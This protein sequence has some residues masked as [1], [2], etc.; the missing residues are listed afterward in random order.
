MKN[1]L[2]RLPCGKEM[3]YPAE[4]VKINRRGGLYVAVS[5]LRVEPCEIVEYMGDL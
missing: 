5:L 1:V 3:I 4:A 2:I